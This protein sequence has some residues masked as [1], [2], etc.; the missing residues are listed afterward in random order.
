M[1]KQNYTQYK[2]LGVANAIGK[3]KE[4]MRDQDL[5]QAGKDEEEVSVSKKVMEEAEVYYESFKHL[6]L[7]KRFKRDRHRSVV[8]E[9]YGV[10][11]GI[12]KTVVT[13]PLPVAKDM[14]KEE[15]AEAAGTFQHQKYTYLL[16]T[17][18]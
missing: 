14:S 17:S 5:N 12:V 1:F 16:L 13:V 10:K 15:F 6:F 8:K 7:P 3:I 11:R 4:Y 9:D 2:R 18:L